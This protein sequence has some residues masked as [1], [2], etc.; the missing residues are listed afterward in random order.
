MNLSVIKSSRDAGGVAMLVPN[1]YTSEPGERG[2][3][4][5]RPSWLFHVAPI[6]IRPITEG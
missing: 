2:A 3:P 6:C 1:M 4:S 5:K